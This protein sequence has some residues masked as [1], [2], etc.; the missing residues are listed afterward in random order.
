[1]Q[2][3]VYPCW[4]AVVEYPV[5]CDCHKIMYIYVCNNVL[6]VHN[7]SNYGLDS[8][9]NYELARNCVFEIY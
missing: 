1:M 7:G 3:N 5:Q 9:S 8:E 2:L 4:D 6:D